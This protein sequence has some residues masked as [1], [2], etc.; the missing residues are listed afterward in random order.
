M[1]RVRQDTISANGKATS[2]SKI[3]PRCCCY[4]P[5]TFIQVPLLPEGKS[6]QEGELHAAG[7]SLHRVMPGRNS[8]GFHLEGKA[9][10]AGVFAQPLDVGL[11][12]AADEGTAHNARL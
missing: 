1:M 2:I 9:D 7:V 10:V 4:M 6:G 11:P 12:S 3:G 8:I 5:L